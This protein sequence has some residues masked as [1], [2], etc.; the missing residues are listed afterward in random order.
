MI[1]CK[2]RQ[3]MDKGLEIAANGV[4]AVS[5]LL[6]GVNSRHTWWTG[7]VGCLLFGYLFFTAQLY[8]DMTLQVFFIGTS[9]VGWWNWTPAANGEQLPVRRTRPKAL[10]A[11]LMAG[12]VVTAGY[13][14]LLHRFT[15]AYAPF[16]DSAV[17]AFSV[18]AQL[19]LM[20]RRYESW[21]CWLLV[22]TI[23]VPL[24]I[25]RGLDI[26]AVLYAM[27]WINALVALVRW[28]KLITP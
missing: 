9:A 5:I 18:L 2:S 25:S 11:M 20:G 26:T 7:I 24:F 21:W 15:H 16:W 1:Q 17:L 10:V 8:A 28:R 27:F 23:S 19:L 4:N 22:N 13:G 14:W 12:V 3:T 6:A